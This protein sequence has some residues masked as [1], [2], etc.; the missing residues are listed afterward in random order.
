[1]NARCILMTQLTNNLEIF[2]RL[3]GALFNVANNNCIKSKNDTN[4]SLKE[5]A[6]KAGWAVTEI[7]TSMILAYQRIHRQNPLPE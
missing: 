7:W 2:I 5:F 6:E 1:M 3:V 4:D